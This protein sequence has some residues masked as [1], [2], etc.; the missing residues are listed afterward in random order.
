[1]HVHVLFRLNTAKQNKQ[2]LCPVEIRL[3]Y[4]KQRKQL[5]S[6]HFLSTTDWEKLQAGTKTRSTA[7]QQVKDFMETFKA[8]L[9]PIAN[10]L[11]M[12]NRMDLETLVDLYAGK[13]KTTITLL[14]LFQLHQE[15]LEKRLTLDRS[16]ATLAKYRY[17]QDKLQDFL[18]FHFQR[19]DIA[20]RN[21]EPSFIQLFY[22]YMLL[23]CRIHHNTIAKYCKN[24]K[25]ILN[26]GKEKG[27]VKD[28]PF[29]AF[30]IGYKDIDRS[31]LTASELAVLERKGMP[32][33]RLQVIKDLFLFQCYTGLSFADLAQLRKEH[34]VEGV[35]AKDWLVVHRQ[36]TKVKSVI[37]LLPPAL[38]ILDRYKDA[39]DVEG[40]QLLPS[41]SNQKLNAYLKEIGDLCRISKPLTSHMGRRTF[42][43]TVALNNGVSLE[44]I[45]RILGHKSIKMTSLYAVVTDL[46]LS[47]EMQ[48]LEKRLSNNQ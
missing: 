14:Q 25:R 6:G 13:P 1:M 34:I 16:K 19:K 32:I 17:T 29:A 43:T 48:A 46:K 7:I 5:A 39:S 24:L 36:K 47:V 20:V 37:P 40:E 44:T 18:S 2:G 9:Y 23:K 15:E 38:V 8:K 42:A 21:L 11:E 28:N 12:E 31:Y 22:D 27:L 30:R 4:Q 33:K 35:D 41:I 45:S 3:T 26:Y 10:S